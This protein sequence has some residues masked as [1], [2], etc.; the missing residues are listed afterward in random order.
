MHATI[1]LYP[2]L[3]AKTDTKPHIAHIVRHNIHIHTS[4]VISGNIQYMNPKLVLLVR[5]ER[6][7][8]DAF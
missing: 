3:S 5:F 1:T 4:D 7:M 2:A 6:A 8:D